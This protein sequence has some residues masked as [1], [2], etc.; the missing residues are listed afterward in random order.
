MR[1]GGRGRGGGGRG[2][3]RGGGGGQRWWDPEWR[4]QKLASMHADRCA[5]SLVRVIRSPRALLQQAAFERCG[6]QDQAEPVDGG[7]SPEASV[8][9]R[10]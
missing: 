8:Q 3:G 7:G 10:E 1:G 5:C 9:G 6:W 4:A 2:G